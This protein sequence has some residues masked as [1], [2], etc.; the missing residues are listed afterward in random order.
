MLD[1]EKKIYFCDFCG[2][3]E[4][5]CAQMITNEQLAIC[6]ACVLS[7]VEILV[8]VSEETKRAIITGIRKGQKQD[9][10]NPPPVITS[11]ND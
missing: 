2:Q 6:D 11:D 9:G 3:D 4:S 5:Q 10:E 8:D 7:C 1:A